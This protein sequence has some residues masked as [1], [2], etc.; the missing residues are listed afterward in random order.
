MRCIGLLQPPPEKCAA[1]AWPND[2]NP[3][4]VVCPTPVPDDESPVEEECDEES[5]P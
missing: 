2:P 5:P 4:R 3:P 1:M